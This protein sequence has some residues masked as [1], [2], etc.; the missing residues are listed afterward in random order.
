MKLLNSILLMAVVLAGSG[1]RVAF[2]ADTDDLQVS[3]GFQYEMSRSLSVNV[4]LALPDG[5][6]ALLSF[7]GEGANGLRLLEN[8]FTGPQGEYSGQLRLPARF[9]RVVMVVR[10]V[11]RQDTFTLPVNADSIAY[12]E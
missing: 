7:Y 12:V 4:A 9:S 8:V 5:N 6:P 10:G 3:A 1:Y 2:S 11:D